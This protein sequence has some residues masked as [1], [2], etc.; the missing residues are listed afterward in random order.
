M[1]SQQ[2]LVASPSLQ[3]RASAPPSSR[4]R[5]QHKPRSG[6]KSCRYFAAPGSRF[7]KH[8]TRDDRPDT[9]DAL[10][11]ELAEAAGDFSSPKNVKL[12]M[13][14]IFHA[15]VQRRLSPKEAGVLCYIAQTI[16]HSHRAIAY[17]QKLENASKP[18]V[19]INDLPEPLR[20]GP[21]YNPDGSIASVQPEEQGP[22]ES[23][24][25]TAYTE[26]A[27][28]GA[29]SSSTSSTSSTPPIVTQPPPA[30]RDLNHFFPRDPT[31]AP[32]LQDP[33][34][35]SMAPPMPAAT[36]RNSRFNHWDRYRK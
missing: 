2:S 34:L 9:N 31:L 3:H 15:L 4:C 28:A 26:P 25:S 12:V 36:R 19:I 30:N 32:G 33:N 1:E 16:L 21:V 18:R 27:T 8:H 11:A 24:A 35:H 6:A 23:S 7:C 5:C 17:Q 22:L 14:K 20:D 13:A 10:A 29:L